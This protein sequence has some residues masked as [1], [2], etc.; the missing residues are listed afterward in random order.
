MDQKKFHRSCCTW[1]TFLILFVVLAILAGGATIYLSYKIKQSGF[2]INRLYPSNVSKENFKDKLKISKENPT[3]SI[4][5]TSAELTSLAGSGI[6]ALAFEMKD[7]QIEIDSQ[8]VIVYGKLTKPL[9]SDIKIET[10]PSPQDGKIF[11]KVTKITTGKLVLPGFLN[12]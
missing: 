2:A 8:S 1:Q 4:T 12:N 6:K 3:F 11:F 5:V 10:V 9:T 7:I